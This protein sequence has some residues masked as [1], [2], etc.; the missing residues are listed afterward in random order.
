M[1][2]AS[3]WNEFGKDVVPSS[4]C[5]ASDF[6]PHHSSSSLCHD[7][8][9]SSSFLY[10]FSLS[11]VTLLFLLITLSF[12][13]HSSRIPS[14]HLM[15]YSLSLPLSRKNS[16]FSF[17]FSSQFHPLLFN[18]SFGPLW[19]IHSSHEEEMGTRFPECFSYDGKRNI[20]GIDVKKGCE[21]MRNS[22][23]AKSW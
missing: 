21:Q 19:S 17:P 15:P 7:S 13:F 11:F 5:S 9:H 16:T 14:R 4:S 22:R 2:R 6:D 10:S 1:R 12:I 20:R 8:S 18:P 23:R 3:L